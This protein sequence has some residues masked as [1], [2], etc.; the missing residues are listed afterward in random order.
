M[1]RQWVRRRGWAVVA[2]SLAAAVGF[3]LTVVS[4]RSPVPPVGAAVTTPLTF[5]IGIADPHEPS[6][7][8]PPSFGALARQGYQGSYINDFL[9]SSLPKGWLTFDGV[10]GGDVGGQFSSSHVSVGGGLLQL[11]TW[12]DPRY[13]GSWVTGGLC[14]CGLP[15]TYGAFFVRSRVTGPGP[16]IVE[17]LWPIGDSWPPEIDFNETGGGVT[18][19]AATVH[20]R[21]GQQQRQLKVAV[22]ETQWHTYGVVWTPS[23]V[24]YL[25]DGRVW[26]EITQP[27][28]IS[29]VPMSLNIQQQTWCL[30][31]FACPSAPQSALVDWVAEYSHVG[32]ET[33]VVGP[34]VTR[35]AT[36]GS[37]LKA[38]CSRV[39]ADVRGYDYRSIRVTGYGVPGSPLAAQ[40]QLAITRARAVAAYIRALL[41][42]THDSVSAT[43]KSLP[44][45]KSASLEASQQRTVLTLSGTLG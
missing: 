7:M 15:H 25:L 8:A 12:P 41:G 16:T 43:W 19:M 38:Q 37:V 36:L 18:S 32:A 40:R 22:N 11:A 13:N 1:E 5:P 3:S 20:F 34:F 24:S 44:F 17:L 30:S 26:G 27:N 23:S 39:V 21:P 4:S 42:P 6:G 33:A 31:A 14:Q 28:E 2:M 9:G 45:T 29:Q 10:P 35:S